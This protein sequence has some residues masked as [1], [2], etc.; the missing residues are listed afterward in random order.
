MKNVLEFVGFCLKV[1]EKGTMRDLFNF[2][3]FV[4]MV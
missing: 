4:L 3:F 1:A 2:V